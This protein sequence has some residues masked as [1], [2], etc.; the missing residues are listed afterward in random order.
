LSHF[1]ATP[2]VYNAY[3]VI[4]FLQQETRFSEEISSFS[5]LKRRK[6]FDRRIV[7]FVSR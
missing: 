3:R 4:S 1:L 5:G 6:V 7:G 2:R